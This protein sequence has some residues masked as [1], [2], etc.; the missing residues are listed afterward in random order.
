MSSSVKPTLSIIIP[1]L[2][3]AALIGTTLDSVARLPDNVEVFV[4]DGNSDD[5][6]CEIARAHGAQV[7]GA[8]RGR[9]SQLHAGA[10]AASGDVLWFLHADTIVPPASA[11]LIFAALSDATVVGGNFAVRF[12]GSGRAAGFMTW[13]YPQLRRLGLCYGDSAIFVRREAYDRAGGFK[14]LPIFEDLDLLR[15]VKTMGKFVHLSATVVTSSRR[16]EEHGFAVTFTGWVLM[17]LL[18]WLG[19]SPNTLGRFYAPPS[20]SFRKTT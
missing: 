3:E 4:V 5:D 11:E 15:E 8:E 6:T 7:I 10:R 2:N 18:Y 9:G 16:F 1:A 17:Q 19:V 13:F 14:A 12:S 20:A